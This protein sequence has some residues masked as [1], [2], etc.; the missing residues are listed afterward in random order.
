MR[1]GHDLVCF[2]YK[3]ANFLRLPIFD[4]SGPDNW[5]LDVK[6]LETLDHKMRT[7]FDKD[8]QKEM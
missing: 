5:G 4:G 7:K 3:V 2:A 8:Q 6:S 1:I